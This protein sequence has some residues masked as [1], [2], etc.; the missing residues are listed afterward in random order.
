MV[1]ILKCVAGLFIRT[2][3]MEES[4]SPA[5]C[6]RDPLLSTLLLVTRAIAAGAVLGCG[7]GYLV[8]G[9][10]EVSLSFAAKGAFA[11]GT[12]SFYSIVCIAVISPGHNRDYSAERAGKRK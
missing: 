3:C 9:Q 8:T 12:M 2:F 1:E 11:F 7:L 5:E 10:L 6:D 4:S